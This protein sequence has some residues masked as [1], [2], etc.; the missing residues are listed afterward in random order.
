MG[1]NFIISNEAI[2]TSLDGEKYFITHG[3]FFDSITLTKKWIAV[4]GDKGYDLLLNLN[5]ILNYIR[6]KIGIKKYWSLSKYIKDNIKKS[7]IFITNFE[8]ILSD[9]AFKKGYSGVICGHI[10]KAEIKKIG[11]IKYKNC[12]DWIENCTALVENLDGT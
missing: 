11:P 4:L 10:H 12:G 9:Y 1:T 2:Y 3:D 8:D 6:K 7:V 5:S